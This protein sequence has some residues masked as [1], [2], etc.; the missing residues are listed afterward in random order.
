MDC[1]IVRFIDFSQLIFQM[2]KPFNVYFDY[3]LCKNSNTKII[4]KFP[5]R[6][7][8]FLCLNSPF[9][10]NSATFY[11]LPYKYVSESSCVFHFKPTNIYKRS[12]WNILFYVPL[13]VK[14]RFLTNTL[15][16]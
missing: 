16:S 11:H 3:K 12:I 15:L 7:I 1:V 5:A 6:Y 2:I 4:R 8:C 9:L 14:L 10:P 13:F